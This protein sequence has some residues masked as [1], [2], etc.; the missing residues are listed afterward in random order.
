MRR[1][2]DIIEDIPQVAGVVNTLLNQLRTT[3]IL[4]S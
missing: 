4:I 1:F 2:R 3:R